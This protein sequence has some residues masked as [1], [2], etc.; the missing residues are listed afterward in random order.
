MHRHIGRVVF[1]AA[2]LA[3]A[4]TGPALAAC[5]A[6]TCSQALRA[7]LDVHCHNQHRRDCSAFCQP[8]YENCLKTGE[9]H[10]RVCEKTGLVRK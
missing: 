6:K 9:F 10:G 8:E 5:G 4:A 1:L 7:C 2:L 3:G